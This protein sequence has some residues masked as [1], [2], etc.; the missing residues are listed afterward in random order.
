MKWARHG[1]REKPEDYIDR[2]RMLVEGSLQYEMGR[3]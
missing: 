3:R 2:A 1:M